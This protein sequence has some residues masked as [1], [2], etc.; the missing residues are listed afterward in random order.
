MC[1]RVRPA[2]GKGTVT[3]GHFVDGGLP[4]SIN[5]VTCLIE[6]MDHPFAGKVTEVVNRL[7][8][9]K[10]DRIVSLC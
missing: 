4:A 2:L 6:W 5:L 7:D 9:G 10:V 1:A 8:L 3:Y